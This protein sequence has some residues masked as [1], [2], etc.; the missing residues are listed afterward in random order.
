MHHVTVERSNGMPTQL[1]FKLNIRARINGPFA[2][3]TYSLETQM[4]QHLGWTLRSIG[5]GEGSI[6]QT[7]I[8][9]KYLRQFF[10]RFPRNN[11]I[12]RLRNENFKP[13][14]DP[15][16]MRY[17]TTNDL[18]HQLGVIYQLMYFHYLLG[19]TELMGEDFPNNCCGISS[20]NLTIALWDAGI[21]A[22]VSTYNAT[23]D[24]AYTIVPFT[25][26]QTGQTGVI[27]ADPT[28]DQMHYD[29][30]KKVRNYLAVLPPE[31]WKYETDWKEG[32]NLYPELVQVSTCAGNT[33][34][35]YT[36]YIQSAFQRPAVV[37]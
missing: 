4:D 16:C 33:D 24:H 32:R 1:P 37:V 13:H 31:G 19:R 9:R 22:A 30:G 28:S 15:V 21:V 10:R 20:R 26:M 3:D 17:E 36:D 12:N 25:I 23:L 34:K 5:L 11:Q 35:G 7:E 2:V 6:E 14:E 29:P 27:L 8:C 18:N